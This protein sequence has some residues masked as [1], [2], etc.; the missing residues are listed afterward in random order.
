M[1]KRKI[2]IAVIILLILL[3][4][5]G[6]V[7]I[8]RSVR[9]EVSES[10]E[11]TGNGVHETETAGNSTKTDEEDSGLELPE[12]SILG[13]EKPSEN[14]PSN[15]DSNTGSEQNDDSSDHG[16]GDHSNIDNNDNGG[17]NTDPAPGTDEPSEEDQG[18]RPV[19]E[20][21]DV[22]IP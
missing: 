13:D 6:I 22:P 3:I 5:L 10:V 21:P 8:K 20:T 12:I 9:K 7:L 19:Y 18:K 2:L 4:I 17:N 16:S 1:K 15:S 14:K 11:N